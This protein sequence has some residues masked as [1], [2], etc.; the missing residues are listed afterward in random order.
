MYKSLLP[1]LYIAILYTIIHLKYP[2]CIHIMF[3]VLL[4]IF[5]VYSPS[6]KMFRNQLYSLL[7]CLMIILFVNIILISPLTQN[8]KISLIFTI[9]LLYR[10]TLYIV[11]M[12]IYKA[13]SRSN[14]NTCLIA[15]NLYHN[16]DINVITNFSEL[17]PKPTI[18][19][20]NYCRDRIENIAFAFIPHKLSIMMFSI[21]KK[22]KMTEKIECPIY[23]PGYGQGNFEN[24]TKQIKSSNQAGNSIFVYINRPSHFDYMT[25]HHSGMYHI[26]KKLGITIT[27]ISID[28]I[29]FSFG[30]IKKQNFFMKVD[31]PFYVDN[32]NTAKYITRRF[33]QKCHLEFKANKYNQNYDENHI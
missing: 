14:E 22:I 3:F 8:I 18:F 5:C 21:F 4:S 19:L 17:S 29:D 26:A 1:F 23:I 20:A 27:P 30:I 31:K 16:C 7:V 25:S 2:K 6:I 12:I 9:L 13:T 10:K 32:V 15:N 33:H 24:I 28:Y 11:F